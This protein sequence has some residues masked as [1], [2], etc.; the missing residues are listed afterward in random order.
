[1]DGCNS[2]AIAF[3]IIFILLVPFNTSITIEPTNKNNIISDLC[4]ILLQL[5]KYI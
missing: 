4:I 3:E 5:K 2:I 1:M